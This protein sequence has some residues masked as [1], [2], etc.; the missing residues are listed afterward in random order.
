MNRI[1]GVDY[2]ERRIGLAL[3]DPLNIFA[4]PFRTIDRKI[5]PDFYYEI[6]KVI[7]E[8]S[9]NQLVVGMPLNMKG[10]DSKQTIIVRDFVES[11]KCKVS[12]PIH[13]LDERLSSKS[14]EQSLI[15]QNES[16]SRNK[17]N[18]DSTAA[19]LIL[20]EFLDSK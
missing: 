5:T 16:P 6:K 12:I 19:C 10:L 7:T 20:Q 17:A 15:F 2:G 13:I 9:V 4:K 14:A 18:I 1:L 11:L 3:S 8:N